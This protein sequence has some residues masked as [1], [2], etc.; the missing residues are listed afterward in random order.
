M[1][2]NKNYNRYVYETS[3]RKYD[4]YYRSDRK[5]Q[6]NT[7]NKKTTP[8]KQVVKTQYQV[9]KEK[10]KNERIQKKYDEFGLKLTEGFDELR[11]DPKRLLIAVIATIPYNLVISY[12]LSASSSVN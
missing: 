2:G 11:D 4:T 1:S 3:P 7:K 8:K 6:S 10:K 5:K 9:Q 12:I